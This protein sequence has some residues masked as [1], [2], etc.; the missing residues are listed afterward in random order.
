MISFKLC[1]LCFHVSNE[2]WV[3]F[4]HQWNENQNIDTKKTKQKNI[5]E[6]TQDCETGLAWVSEDA[7]HQ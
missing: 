3:K 4:Y 7:V 5:K 2:I 1:F 6:L